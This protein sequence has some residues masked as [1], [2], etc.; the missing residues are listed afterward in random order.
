MRNKLVSVALIVLTL[1]LV[2]GLAVACTVVTSPIV[3]KW[4]DTQLGQYIEFS[5]DGH[6][7]F[8][9]G[10]NIITGKYEIISDNYVKVSFEGITG[11]FVALFGGDTWKFQVSGDTMML[12]YGGKTA[13]LRRVR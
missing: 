13:T 2:G 7:I 10:K 1:V 4:Q 6:V 3:G 11:A 9:D 12:S 8:D 5:R